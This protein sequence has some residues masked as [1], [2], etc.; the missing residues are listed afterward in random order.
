MIILVS[1]PE[2]KEEIM[3]HSFHKNIHLEKSHLIQC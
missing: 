2:G 3:Q 1:K